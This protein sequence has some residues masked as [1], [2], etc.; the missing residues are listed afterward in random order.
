MEGEEFR[1]QWRMHEL[2]LGASWGLEAGPPACVQ[3][4]EPPL[5]VCRLCLQTLKTYCIQSVGKIVFMNNCKT[6]LR[7]I[8]MEG[9]VCLR[10]RIAD[11]LSSHYSPCSVAT[12]LTLLA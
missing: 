6:S 7:T 1:A 10:C 12:V 8:V 11:L 4:T 9:L 2:V 3:E 5:S